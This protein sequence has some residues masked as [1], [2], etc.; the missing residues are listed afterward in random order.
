MAHGDYLMRVSL[1]VVAASALALTGCGDGADQSVADREPEG[2]YG[3]SSGDNP[4]LADIQN[5]NQQMDPSAQS[6]L[7]PSDVYPSQTQTQ[8][9]GQDRTMTP[10]AE[11][12]RGSAQTGAT[13]P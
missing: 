2:Q 7:S 1:F 11:G 3:A 9:A 5:Q 6:G 10:G 12:G 4:N 8:P 13:N